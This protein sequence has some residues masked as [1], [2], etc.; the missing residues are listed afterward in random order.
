MD[1]RRFLLTSLAGVLPV[2]LAVQ[3]QQTGKVYRIGLVFSALPPT[4]PN[5][6]PF[7][8]RMREL[9]WVQ[10]R[11]FVAEY[12]VCGERY[13]LVPELAAELI[14]AGADLFVV[15]GGIE[16]SRVQQV[17]HTIPIVTTRAGDLVAMGLAVSLARPG[18]NV[19][20][21]QT[22]RLVT[23]HLSLLKDAIP[24]PARLGII[25]HGSYGPSWRA[26]V[27]SGAKVLGVRLQIVSVETTDEFAGAFSAF[28]AER[29]QGL[30]VERDAFMSAHANT[31]ASFA[32]RHRLATISDLPQ[33]AAQGGLM[34]YGYSVP[35][36]ERSAANIVDKILRGAKVSEVP[37]QQ[38][39]TFR[40]VINLK[41]AK[42]LGLTI[43]PSLLARADQVIE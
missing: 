21:I 32:L 18:G 39:T 8:E 2:P 12:R 3:A 27:E 34:S 33:L 11:D 43:P 31:L 36:V 42:A 14:R 26:E 22:P 19:T 1:R 24:R 17:T 37:V 20:G 10:G 16:A 30:V 25:V 9:G 40:L 15:Q 35:D 41:T 4:F 38:A 7:Y 6:W 13:D 28:H 29:A 23:K 5:Q